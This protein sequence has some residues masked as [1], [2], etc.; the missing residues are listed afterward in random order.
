MRP[1]HWFFLVAAV[2]FIA[3]IGFIIAGA[4][5]ARRAPAATATVVAT[6]PVASVKQ[7]MKGIVDPASKAVF[8]SVNTVETKEGI[9]EIA[10]HTDAEWEAVG[11]SA[12]AL[13]ESGNMILAKGRAVDQGDWVTFS[14]AMIESSEAALKATQAK[15]P[16][17]LF[18]SG[19][20][21][22]ESCDN[23]HRKYQRVF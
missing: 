12:A 22:Y 6:T 21:I 8:S 9:Q 1:L 23:C 15:N 11:S 7:I 20:T 17:D 5:M 16:K 13:I 10:P 14:K 3:G 2:L 18:S 4:R 19:G